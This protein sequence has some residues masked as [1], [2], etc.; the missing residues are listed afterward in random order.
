MRKILMLFFAGLLFIG[1][2][3][4]FPGSLRGEILSYEWPR[5]GYLEGT[6]VNFRSGPSTDSKILGQFASPS[7]A[8]EFVVL[9]ESSTEDSYP[10]Y[11]VLCVS[12]GE[13]W[14]YG[15]YLRLEENQSPVHRY[16]MKI[17]DDYGISPELALERYGS[18]E[19]SAKE[20]RYIPD[21]NT[22]VVV[23]ILVFH[24]HEAVY[25]NRQLQSIALPGGFMGFGDIFLGMTSRDVISRIGQV[26]E[27]DAELW[28]YVSGRDS[29]DV[30]WG[31]GPG[32]EKDVVVGLSY[33][34]AV[35]E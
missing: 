23:E 26:C 21:F 3:P 22:H 4:V 18:P 1:A 20:E 15:K 19:S 10:W 28:S 27:G 11:R 32:G 9:G 17:R 14:L 12:F 16:A 35:F 2:T 8:G 29:I 34:R 5:A 13:G 31:E 33:R 24:G 25:W 7:H 30:E 6:R